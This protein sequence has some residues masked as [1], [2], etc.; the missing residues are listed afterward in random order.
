VVDATVVVGSFA[1]GDLVV[2]SDT[3]DI[4]RVASALGAPLE[5]L[6]I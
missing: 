3:N 5:I 6:R 1:R 4:K 2:T